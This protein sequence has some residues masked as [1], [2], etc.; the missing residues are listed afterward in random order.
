MAV[1]VSCPS[2]EKALQV[3][4]EFFGKMVQCPECKTRFQAKPAADSLPAKPAPSTTDPGLEF[5]QEDP[6]PRKPKRRSDY[7]DDDLSIRKRRE[8]AYPHRGDLI[9]TLGIVSIVGGLL[10]CLPW[11]IAPIVWAMASHDLAEMKAGRMDPTG[12]S[13]TQTGRILAIISTIL[14]GLGVAV[15]C[16]LIGLI[17]AAN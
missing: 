5:T 17:A 14:V 9:M 11:F 6:T 2:C 7:D 12:E 1:V 4:E 15:I 8:Y 10:F 3:P 16:G 13:S